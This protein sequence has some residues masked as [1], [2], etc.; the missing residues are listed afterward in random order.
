MRREVPHFAKRE[1][2]AQASGQQDENSTG[3]MDEDF[4]RDL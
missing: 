3:I 2:N 1:S 4:A